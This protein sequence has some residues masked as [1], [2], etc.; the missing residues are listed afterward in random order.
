ME[1]LKIVGF[2]KIFFLLN[3]KSRQ[4]CYGRMETTLYYKILSPHLQKQEIH[5]TKVTNA[6]GLKE[7]LA[8]KK[9]TKY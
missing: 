2:H 9:L 6:I 8:P 5:L 4:L 3:I 1:N 7:Q